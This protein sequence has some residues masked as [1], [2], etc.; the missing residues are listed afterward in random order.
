MQNA[1]IPAAVASS[2]AL[3]PVSLLGAQPLTPLHSLGTYCNLGSAYDN[4]LY[5]LAEKWDACL[6]DK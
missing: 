6:E 5:R 1:L 2:R 4:T 3:L